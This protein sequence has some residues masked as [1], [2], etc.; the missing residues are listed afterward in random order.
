M[1]ERPAV[2]R[3]IILLNLGG[4]TTM[5]EVKPFLFSLFYDPAIITLPNPFRWIL[6]QFITR[7][8][9]HEAAHIYETLGGKSPLLEE[10]QKQATALSTYLD[11]HSQVFIAMRHA[12]PRTEVAFHA[13]R[14]WGAEEVVLLPLYP[15]FSTTTTG[16]AIKAWKT[17][18][19][20]YHWHPKT[21]IVSSYPT[22]PGFIDPLAAEIQKLYEQAKT[23]GKPKVILSAHG[24][25]EKVIQAGDPYQSQVEATAQAILQKL[26]IPAVEVTLSYQSRVGPLPWLKPYTNTVLREAAQ[27]KRPIIMVPISFVSEH[28]ETLYELDKMYGHLARE[29]GSPAYFRVPTVSCDSAF[30]QGLYQLIQ[31]AN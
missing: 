20:Q 11:S 15:Q 19:N 22:I 8:R 3:A 25:P 7:A 6:A 14:A 23:F 4:P 13:A 27:N 29:N 12:T 2:K 28:S 24:L 17:L 18:E 26:G 16:S 9:Y 1:G 31:V 5:A 10:T 30:I 21:R